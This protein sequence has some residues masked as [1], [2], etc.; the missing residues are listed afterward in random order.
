M[1]VLVPLPDRPG[2]VV[3]QTSDTIPYAA[4]SPFGADQ[5]GENPVGISLR[6]EPALTRAIDA[7]PPQ[8]WAEAAEY[9][10]EWGEVEAALWPAGESRDH[11]RDR[12]TAECVMATA[13]TRHFRDDR[14]FWVNEEG[15]SQ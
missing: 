13:R 10:L 5:R 12:V 1:R 4:T 7:A 8:D 9:A 14:R 15:W 11:A 6:C 2:W 3:R